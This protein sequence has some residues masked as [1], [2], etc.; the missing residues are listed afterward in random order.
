VR[1]VDNNILKMEFKKNVVYYYDDM[2]GTFN[3]SVGHPMK[4]MRVA[5]TD[6]LVRK[7]ELYPKM[8]VIVRVLRR[9]TAR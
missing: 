4:P 3:Y 8:D 6:E 9:R 1:G 2:I 7:Y 5:M